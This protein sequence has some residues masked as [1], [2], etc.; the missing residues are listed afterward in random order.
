M[1]TELIDSKVSGAVKWVGYITAILSLF[2]MLVGI[3]RYV[4]NR[5]ETNRK[6]VTLISSEQ[7][8]ARGR[9]YA[10]AWQTLEQAS[11][12][13]PNS[14]EVLAAQVTLAEEW[15]EDIHVQEP[16]KFSDVTAKVEPVLTRS[17]A[18][19]KPGEARADLLSHLGWAYFLESR[20]GRDNLDPAGTYAQAIADDPN[21]PYAQAMW[22]HWILWNGGKLSDA[23]QHFALAM[24]S[25]RQGDFVRRLQ[26]G[27]LE[28]CSTDECREEIVRVATVMRKEQQTVDEDMR[29]RILNIYYFEFVPQ[30]SRTTRFIDAV[31]RAEHVATFRWLFDGLDLDD[32]KSVLRT[33]YLAA[34]QDAAGQDND[35][36]TN[37]RLVHEKMPSHSGPVAD[38]TDAAIKRLSKSH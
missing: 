29:R 3:V 9:D 4:A 21:N 28:D 19:S 7:L 38:A 35:A 5:V 2:A 15:L 17:I 26:L 24:T 6:I 23:E 20:D 18:S 37:Y 13:K 11:N 33:Y 34:L 12:L 32:S 16:E 25:Q 8:Q 36:L 1:K 30:D 22:G 27:A 14:S 31:P 10:S